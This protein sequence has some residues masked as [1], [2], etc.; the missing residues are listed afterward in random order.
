M[1][2]NLYIISVLILLLISC[3]KNNSEP[4]IEIFETSLKN[5]QLSTG[6]NNNSIPINAAE[7]SVEYVKD[8]VSGEMFLDQSGQPLVLKATGIIELQNKWLKLERKHP[9][10]HLTLSLKENLTLNP[11]KFLIGIRADGNLDEISI[12]Q[13]RGRGYE[14]VKKEI[15]EV[16][17]SRI[18]S[19]TEDGLHAIT[20][21]NNDHIA[22]YIDL[23]DMFK[24]VKH[25]SEFT[26][27]DDDAFNWVDSRDTPMFLEEI[28]KDGKIYWSKNVSYKK[29][30]SFEPYLTVGGSKIEILIKANTSVKAKGKITY[31]SRESKYTLSIKNISSGNTFDV[32]GT[33]KQKVPVSTSVEILK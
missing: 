9:N 3:K 25:M 28:N 12:T 18:E 20:L 1:S 11:R 22:K 7:W 8:G 16:P 32:Y 19:T 13:T 5:L 10:D 33:W 21:T 17:G 30:Q 29:G 6:F 27:S 24:D 15:T 4:K 2:K 26:S 31:L 23:Y 14:I